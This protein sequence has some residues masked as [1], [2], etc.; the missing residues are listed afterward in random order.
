MNR[1]KKIIFCSLLGFLILAVL[2]HFWL[3]DPYGVMR[4]VFNLQSPLAKFSQQCS[5]HSP[6]WLGEISLAGVD[7]LKALA[8]QVAFINRDG[9]LSHCETGWRSTMLVSP[10]VN[11]ATRFRYGSLTKPVTASA[12]I[13]LINDG[14]LGY[15]DRLAKGL[16][17][18]E[19]SP[20]SPYMLGVTIEQ[21]LRHRSGV[22]GEVFLTRE[23]P[24][25][26]DRLALLMATGTVRGAGEF[27]Y[28]NLGYCL[29]GEVIANKTGQPYKQAIDRLFSLGGRGIRFVDYES[30]IDEVRRDFRFNDF[31]GVNNKGR[32]DYDAVAATAGLSGSASAY[33]RL[34][35]DMIH[36]TD[37]GI[38]SGFDEECDDR[39]LKNCYG[40]AFYSYS[41]MSGKRLYVKEG[42]M[43]GASGVVVINDEGEVFVWLGNSDTENAA[44]GMAMKIF[45]DKLVGL[46]F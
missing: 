36:Q 35:K 4:Q 33:A 8:T 21:L 29:L 11:E 40:Y 45:L 20:V 18:R 34:I 9:K 3:T 6:E 32:F 43:P 42:Y 10:A 2:V 14:A 1:I 38:L 37:E 7:E 5:E 15:Q 23:K 22:Q 28:S 13:A 31:Y 30:G 41:P 46:G 12:I 16:Q 39:S 25:C 24:V 17:Q 27:K 44:S 19:R 26:P